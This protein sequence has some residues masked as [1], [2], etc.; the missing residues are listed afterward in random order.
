MKRGGPKRGDWVCHAPRLMPPPTPTFCAP[1]RIRS[2]RRLP[3]RAL[4]M[5]AHG[6]NPMETAYHKARTDDARERAAGRAAADDRVLPP[7]RHHLDP[8]RLRRALRQDPGGRAD[9]QGPDD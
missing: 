9:E 6:S 8:R 3:R 1:F 7:L 2:A 5:E 4:G